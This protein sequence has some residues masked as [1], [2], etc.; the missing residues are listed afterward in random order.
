L[1][2]GDGSIRVFDT[3]NIIEKYKLTGHKKSV[4]SVAFHPQKNILVSGGYDAYLRFW[5]GEKH[6]EQIQNIPAHNY[7]IYDIQFNETGD[8]CATASRDKTIKIWDAENF[9]MP[10]RLDRKN[11]NGHINSVNKLLW[12]KND[13][14]ISSG[15]DQSIIIWKVEKSDIS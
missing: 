6:F 1:A 3:N 4:Y 13:L 15:D 11:Y 14:L 5:N 9:L 12:F 2:C 7:A 8:I 10:L